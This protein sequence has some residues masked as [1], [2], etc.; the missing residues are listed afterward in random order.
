MSR[1]SCYRC[2]DTR[3][4]PGTNPAHGVACRDCK[5]IRPRCRGPE[6]H[7]EALADGLCMAHYQQR[8]RAPGRPLR[9]L[10]AT[11]AAPHRISV[12]LSE[13]AMRQLQAHGAPRSIA[14]D[15]L[16]RWAARRPGLDDPDAPR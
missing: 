13:L 10:R 14:R 7:N 6:C 8:R 5:G 12:R 9:P 4:E 1:P 11:A 2:G 3:R 15:V 16:E